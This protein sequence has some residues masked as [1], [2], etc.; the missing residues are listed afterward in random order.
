MHA[1]PNQ[2]RR[3][4][5]LGAATRAEVILPTTPIQGIDLDDLERQLRDFVDPSG[6]K[7]SPP[8]TSDHSLAKRARIVGGNNPVSGVDGR[9]DQTAS[10]SSVRPSIRGGSL[11]NLQS[12]ESDA[13]SGRFASI[14]RASQT[15]ISRR[16]SKPELAYGQ[17]QQAERAFA[18]DFEERIIRRFDAGAHPVAAGA[19]A[20]LVGIEHVA[21]APYAA[22]ALR[23]FRERSVV[24][25]CARTLAVPLLLLTL[26][27]GTA[28]VMLS[29]V[30]EGP[31]TN[32]NDSLVNVQAANVGGDD[33]TP[34]LSALVPAV[35]SDKP[36]QSVVLTEQ[37]PDGV[38][39]PAAAPP[40]EAETTQ[41]PASPSTVIASGPVSASEVPVIKAD[42]AAGEV[43]PTNGTGDDQ[44]RSQAALDPARSSPTGSQPVVVAEQS[45]DG[46][47][48]PGQAQPQPAQATA[49][50]GMAIVS[51]PVSASEVP[52][53]K[54][55]DAAVGVP[56]AGVAVDDRTRSRSAL[57]PA[58][59]S[60]T[61]TQPVVVAE[62]SPDGVAVPDAAAS[63]QAQ[64]AQATASPGMAIVPSSATE[65][66]P[67]TSRASDVKAPESAAGPTVGPIAAD[68]APSMPTPNVP[69][70]NPPRPAKPDGM[71]GPKGQPDTPSLTPATPTTIT[72]SDTTT[73]VNAPSATRSSAAPAT[74]K[75]VFTRPAKQ[76]AIIAA[77]HS[78]TLRTMK[79]LAG[80]TEAK[81][82]D[83]AARTES[84]VGAPLLITPLAPGPILEASAA[85]TQAEQPAGTAT[86]VRVKST[87]G[88]SFSIRLASSLSESDARATLSQLQKQFP[89]ALGG[90]SIGRDNLGSFG[91]FY[92]VRVGSLSR[93]AADKVCSQLR[94][95]GRKCILTRVQK[96]GVVE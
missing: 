72:S 22:F 12:R 88:P 20:R 36:S 57:D 18:S 63:V 54:T 3:P 91:V 14:T 71:I 82:D 19:T 21:A 16:G 30:G 42:D 9:R 60:P 76:S 62:Q 7:N 80:S 43:S 89:G 64:P 56:P 50:P 81:V 93:E 27:V 29:P 83:N 26:G 47:A 48:S 17:K 5:K 87:G 32:A 85:P 79:P 95:V 33:Q 10:T 75:P 96:D 40:A 28:V 23:S 4:P 92:R 61:S 31:E 41:A 35:S 58:R 15:D 77:G 52:V 70:P 1:S 59:S 46:V 66:L 94:A 38:A 51:G 13:E 86:D 67:A 37:S 44:I 25:R 45:P 6:P 69:L 68:S 65:E 39:A 24:S 78:Q 55:D 8:L 2:V 34:S 84:D 53:S 74:N 73:S 49:S 90:G 11:G